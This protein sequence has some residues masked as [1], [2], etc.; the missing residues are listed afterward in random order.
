[1]VL[2]L[3]GRLP[4]TPRSQSALDDVNEPAS[5]TSGLLAR[6]CARLFALQGGELRVDAARPSVRLVLPISGT[7]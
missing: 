4:G 5:L 7:P 2:E 1:M 6:G 3:V